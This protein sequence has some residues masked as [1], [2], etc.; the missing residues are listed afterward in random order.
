MTCVYALDIPGECV[1]LMDMA[2]TTHH[3]EPAM[4][5]PVIYYA[6]PPLPADDALYL[7]DNGRCTCADHA[8]EYLKASIA[9]KPDAEIHETP[10]GTWERFTAHDIRI[11]GGGIDCEECA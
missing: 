2:T 3:K 1:Y 4:K 5:K 11:F 8:G 9:A 7:D 6:E 10:L